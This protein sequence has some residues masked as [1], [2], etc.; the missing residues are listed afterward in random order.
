MV[1][2]NQDST[3]ARISAAIK[4]TAKRLKINITVEDNV[5]PGNFLASQILVT[6]MARIG[7]ALEISIPDNCYIFHDKKTKRQLTITE[8]TQKLLKEATYEK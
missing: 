4:E 5:C 2:L 7:R 1:T 3:K 6:I 8:A